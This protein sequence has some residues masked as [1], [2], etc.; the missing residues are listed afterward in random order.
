[1]MESLKRA[2]SSLIA[3]LM[4]P[5]VVLALCMSVEEVLPMVL[6]ELDALPPSW[7]HPVAVVIAILGAL[8][9]AVKFAATYAKAQEDKV[10]GLS[11]ALAKNA[12]PKDGAP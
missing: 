7:R 4:H 8:L 11:A 1:M 12:P 5:A 2:W 3:L 6:D 10:A 9:R